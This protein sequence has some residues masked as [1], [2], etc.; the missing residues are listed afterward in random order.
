MSLWP[1]TAQILYDHNFR[2]NSDER[3]LKTNRT[4]LQLTDSV[5]ISKTNLVACHLLI[6]P[7]V[8][9]ASALLA[10]CNAVHQLRMHS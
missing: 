8:L 9:L 7:E 6:R 2:M 1:F 3:K 5:A 10:E 4:N